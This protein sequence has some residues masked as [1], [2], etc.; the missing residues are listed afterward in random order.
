MIIFKLKLYIFEREGSGENQKAK[1]CHTF[2]MADIQN[3]TMIPFE[4]LL[5][6]HEHPLK[7][8]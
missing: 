3:I 5:I 8:G 2:K 6:K 4:D 1:W 7:K